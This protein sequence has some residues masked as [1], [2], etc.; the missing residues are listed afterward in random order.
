MSLSPPIS[1]RGS[2]YLISNAQVTGAG[3]RT[4]RRRRRQVLTTI[5]SLALQGDARL[6]GP[7]RAVRP[8]AGE[9][10]APLQLT[11]IGGSEARPMLDT[12]VRCRKCDDCLKHRRRLWSA[13]AASMIQD[14]ERSWMVTLTLTPEAHFRMLCLAERS[15]RSKGFDPSDWTPSEAFAARWGEIAKEVTKWLKR[16]RATGAAFNYLLVAEA[17]ASGLPHV[18]LLMHE[19]RG[20][21]YRR[22]TGGWSLGFSHAKLVEGTSAARYVTKYLMKSA[23]ARVRASLRYGRTRTTVSNQSGPGQRDR[24]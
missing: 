2:A 8:L 3:G 17:H 9:C 23:M 19:V 7:L 12:F 10:T 14:H 16:T 18:H 11:E 24:Y 1:R 15:A 4:I 6:T 20:L 5:R 21:T 22:I 13:K